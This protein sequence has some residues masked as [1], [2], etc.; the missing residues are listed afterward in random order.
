MRKRRE[1]QAVTSSRAWHGLAASAT[2]AVL[3][4]IAALLAIQLVLRLVVSHSSL[5]FDVLVGRF[6]APNLSGTT[7]GLIAAGGSPVTWHIAPFS[8]HI[9]VGWILSEKSELAL[10]GAG[11]IIGSLVLGWFVASTSSRLSLP[12]WQVLAVA[13]ALYI[14]LLCGLRAATS[15]SGSDG[16]EVTTSMASAAALATCWIAIIGGMVVR[17]YKPPSRHES[18]A[19]VI[20]ARRTHTSNMALAIALALLGTF[21]SSGPAAASPAISKKPWRARGVDAAV[22]KLK[23]E[24]GREPVLADDG[25]RGVPSMVGELRS[26]IPSG[27][28]PAWLN[29]HAALFG[30]SGF[31]GKLAKDTQRT[32]T[33]D[34]T[35]DRHVW[36]DQTVNGVPVYGARLGIHTDPTGKKVTGVSNGFRQD[37]AGPASTTPSVTKEAATATASKALPHS[38]LATSPALVVYAAAAKAN[39]SAAASLVWQVDLTDKDGVSGRY[40]VD[41]LEKGRILGYESLTESALNRVVLDMQHTTA[42]VGNTGIKVGRIE[43]GF[44]S[45]DADTDDA[46]DQTGNVYSYYNGRFHRD[47]IDDEG[48]DLVSRVHYGVEY[49]NAF[50]SSSTENMTF[51]DGMLSQD[52]TGHELTHGVTS[53]TANLEYSFESGALNESISDFFGE[54]T[55]YYS[56]GSNDWLLGT[57]LK[58]MKPIRSM[59]DPHMFNQPATMSEYQQTCNDNGGVHLNSGIPNLAF[60]RLTDQLGKS[61]AENVI[62]RALTQYLTPTSTF[63]DAYAATVSASSELF[64]ANSLQTS[65]TKW[66]WSAAGIDS[67]TPDPRPT[68]CQNGGG[69]VIHCS[70]LG[71]MYSDSAALD[72]N[73]ARMEDVI[74]SLVHMYQLG[75]VTT[76]PAVTYYE[77]LFLDNREDL[78]AT[79]SLEGPL[80]DKFVQL[81][82]T[83][84]PIMESLGTQDAGNVRVTQAQIDTA[85]AFADAVVTAAQQV[86]KTHLADLVTQERGK[87]DAQHVVGMSVTDAQS[88]MDGVATRITEEQNAPGTAAASLAATYDNTGITADTSTGPGNIDGSGNSLSATALNKAGVSAGSTLT[89]GGLALA[90]PS[91]AGQGKPDNTV[92]AGQTIAL[93]GSGSTLGFLVSATNGPAGGIGIVHYSDG[94]AQRFPLRSPDWTTGD[95][96]VAVATTYRNVQ[97]NKTASTSAAVYYSGVSLLP[98]LTPVSVTLP[99]ASSATSQT[100]ALHIFAMARGNAAGS[101]QSTF[102]NVAVTQDAATDLGDLDGGGASFSAQAFTKGGVSAAGTVSHAGLTF[103]W[104]TT[105]GVT[106]TDLSRSFGQ[107]DNTVAYGQNI[108]IDSTHGNTLGFLVSSSYGPAGGT[109]HVN[110]SDGTTQSFTLQSPDWFGGTGDTAITTAYQNRAGNETYQAP[111]YVYYAG[112]TLNSAKTPVSVTLP[113]VSQSAQQDPTLHVF[114][115]ARG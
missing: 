110:Y 12:K 80:L 48:S 21:L 17:F 97:G 52:V 45:G 33:K 50:W 79:L 111:A 9:T 36:Y 18:I 77:G 113:K 95:G 69:I 94:T 41:A 7:A 72:G 66:V 88:Y 60:Y 71:E 30:V 91:T 6:L 92:A 40:F 49:K 38:S 59:R 20:R 81:A 47:G 90:W 2:G 76:S 82:Q 51:G 11:P 100:P 98:G 24:S 102:N 54:M 8:G 35:G 65:A 16:M 105:A 13:G 67:N 64:G 3:S 10:L 86:G 57:D 104:P 5:Y 26:P 93:N 22:S 62:Y 28:V 42:S 75:T 63:A 25:A 68:D 99:S 96:D 55:E 106:T 4:L 107:P 53:H 29:D 27:G 74:G 44:P 73:G 61:G 78:D 15:D 14:A 39:E 32:A 83:W 46:F 114:A 84:Q 56:T 43:G 19:S 58:A 1:G 70:T 37:L 109:A 34:T 103:Q 108:A 115:M 87:F 101:L 85:N 31:S 112:V 23:K 89:H